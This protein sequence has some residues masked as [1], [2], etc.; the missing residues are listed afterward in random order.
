MGNE[1]MTFGKYKGQPFEV[2]QAD[3]QYCNWLMAQDWFRDKFQPVYN[4]IVNN[5]G[6]AADTPEHNILQA[7]FINDDI[8]IK[9]AHSCV[10]ADNYFKDYYKR[11]LA[12]TGSTV[13]SYSY[14]P[15]IYIP[16][17]TCAR[18]N[19]YLSISRDKITVENAVA[20][21][22]A[23]ISNPSKIAVNV[24]NKEF[25][26]KGWDVTF[27]VNF[28]DGI[29]DIDRDFALE[30]KPV[31]GDDYPSILRQM[32]ANIDKERY[33]V[34]YGLITESYTGCVEYNSMKEMFR[35][36]RF[37]VRKLSELSNA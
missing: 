31:V 6:E 18:I 9:V 7:R 14:S 12:K 3:P 32:K 2:L 23:Y 5:F 8:C 15:I 16:E 34:Y 21:L 20:S 35:S 24:R 22:N 37:F 26:H 28:D 19:D 17:D 30:L 13:R 1:I 29:T 4:L 25:E 11:E 27:T 10:D 36:S 33:G